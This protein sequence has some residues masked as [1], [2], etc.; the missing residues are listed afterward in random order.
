MISKGPPEEDTEWHT[1]DIYFIFLS[2]FVFFFNVSFK[3]LECIV[4]AHWPIIITLH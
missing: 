4:Y 2:I 1:A 3:I